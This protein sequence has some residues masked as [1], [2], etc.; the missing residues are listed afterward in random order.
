MVNLSGCRARPDDFAR[1]KYARQSDEFC[2]PDKHGETQ[3]V[4]VAC[5][6][7]ENLDIFDAVRVKEF[8]SP[9]LP[10]DLR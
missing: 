8:S 1:S 5:I 7:M 10:G 9:D 4:V 6:C 3:S 2:D